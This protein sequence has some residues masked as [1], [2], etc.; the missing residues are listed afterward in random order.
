MSASTR[1]ENRSTTSVDTSAVSA[2]SNATDAATPAES[3]ARPQIDTSG[4]TVGEALEGVT[5]GNRK[6]KLDTDPVAVAVNKA[7]AGKVYPLTGD[8]AK[9]EGVRSIARRAAARRGVGINFDN[10]RESEGVVLFRV[11][12]KRQTKRTKAAEGETKA[13]E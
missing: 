12:A 11:G 5:F 2:T 7:E 10:S 6:T 8:A 13:A 1:R 4:V 9:M 3:K